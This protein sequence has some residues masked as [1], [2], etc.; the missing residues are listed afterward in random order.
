MVH[1]SLLFNVMLQHSFVPSDF[2]NGIITPLPKD[3]H[4]D[5]TSL[6]MYRGITSAP[7]LSKVIESVLLCIY[8][9]FLVS[10]QLQFGFKKKSSC[11]HALFTVNES[12]KYYTK[13]GSKVYCGFFAERN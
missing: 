8:K 6:D 11:M 2:C 5:A 4:G 3:K 12:V 10:D 7:A 1:L 9:D 13:R